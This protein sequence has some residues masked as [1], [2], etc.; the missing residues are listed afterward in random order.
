MKKSEI[1]SSGVAEWDGCFPVSL[2]T[3]PLPCAEELRTRTGPGSDLVY[4]VITIKDRLP[5]LISRILESYQEI[6]GINNIDGT[7]LP[8]KRAITQICEDLLQ[9]L[10]PGF[11]D[12]E[13]IATG[14][15][16][17]I[18]S[19]RILSIVDR[20]R[21]ETFKSLRLN[22]PECPSR[23]AD[24][25]VLHLI[26]ELEP[27]R[28]LLQTDVEAAY[29]G[30]PASTSFNEIIVSYPC[31]EAIA[32]QRLAHILYRER[33]PLIPRIMTEW[34]HGRTG[35]DIHPGA[36]IGSHFF[37]DHG[38]GV[39]I[40]ET[41]RIGSH[42]KLYHGVTLGARSFQKD[43]GGKIK[44]GGKR[45]PN[46]GDWVTIYPNA[47]ILGGETMIGSGSTIGANVFLMESVPPD[48]LVRNERVFTS[49]VSKK[50]R[51][52][53]ISHLQNDLEPLL[54]YEI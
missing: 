38:T 39:V 44:K 22:E 20:L 24:Q 27:L 13:P 3:H 33:L 26:G 21:I 8:S 43:E 47:T 17:Q 45:H 49:I 5:A 7:N 11:H 18:T 12:E 50:N 29:E 15:V 46:V 48:S 14:K 54:N 31:V 16:P 30:D 51:S 32:I 42:V 25:I 4:R 52:A 2:L 28:E 40:G 23:R 35:I 53:G 41:C 34:A 1:R 10:F 37:I 6:G 36:E 19:G 9:I